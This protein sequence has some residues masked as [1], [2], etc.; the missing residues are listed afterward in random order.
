[1]FSQLDMSWQQFKVL[2]TC[3]AKSRMKCYIGGRCDEVRKAGSVTSCPVWTRCIWS[4]ERS[5][6]S[7]IWTHNLILI[8]WSTSSQ[9]SSRS[10]CVTWTKTADEPYC[11]NAEVQWST[12]EAQLLWSCC[13]TSTE[14]HCSDKKHIRL[15][16]ENVWNLFQVGRIELTWTGYFANVNPDRQFAVQHDAE[17]T[18]D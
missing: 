8:H 9:C 14:D 3:W 2:T 17:V 10:T 4:S 6:T 13:R 7:L 15:R 5:C 16:T 11:T 1:M 18:N 12:L